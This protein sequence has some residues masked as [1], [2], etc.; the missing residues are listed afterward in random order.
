MNE[1]E[2]QEKRK[3]IY[4]NRLCAC[5]SIRLQVDETERRICVSVC[6][7]VQ[8]KWEDEKKGS[9]EMCNWRKQLRIIIISVITFSFSF[10]G[11]FFIVC[12]SFPCYVYSHACTMQLWTVKLPSRSEVIFHEWT[13]FLHPPRVVVIPLLPLLFSCGNVKECSLQEFCGITSSSSQQRQQPHKKGQFLY[14]NEMCM[15]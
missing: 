8:G 12:V 4:I 7:C 11:F 15:A 5:H 9:V 13:F 2:W 10:V 14:S 3:K 1:F 6:V